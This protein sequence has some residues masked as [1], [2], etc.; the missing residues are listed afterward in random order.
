LFIFLIGTTYADGVLNIFKPVCANALLVSLFYF[1]LLKKLLLNDYAFQYTPLSFNSMKLAIFR[2][3]NAELHDV[4]IET[5][6]IP[7]PNS[8]LLKFTMKIT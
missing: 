1:V 6:G 4:N 5:L 3:I 8:F 7:F 2:S